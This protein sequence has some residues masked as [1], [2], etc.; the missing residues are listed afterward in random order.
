MRQKWLGL[1]VLVGVSFA[2]QGAI[3]EAEKM[4][5][6][7]GSLRK[8]TLLVFDID[9]TILQTAQTLGSVQWADWY[10]KELVKKGIPNDE[11][12]ELTSR[13]WVRINR[14]SKSE[15]V[16]AVT[17]NIIANLQ[18]RGYQVLALTARPTS[19]AL[20]T[21]RD[22]PRF[23]V[24]F[25]RSWPNAKF[26]SPFP[27]AAYSSGILFA[28]QTN[29]KGAVLKEFLRQNGVRPAYVR[30]VDD[31]R[32]YVESVEEAMQASAIPYVGFRYGGADYRVNSFDKRLATFQHAYF[33][34]LGVILSDARAKQL[35][36][37]SGA[38][39]AAN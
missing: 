24:R 36:K 31:K 37:A 8:G 32:K 1:L 19:I 3:V 2:A 9:N 14:V 28:G 34:R 27:G 38:I 10:Q 39:S 16:E 17:P 35:M 13:E 30:F 22:L 29:S 5:E 20:Q 6:T 33:N 25:D 7:V 21:V 23:G 12:G 26:Q 18:A 4:A 15:L 11:A